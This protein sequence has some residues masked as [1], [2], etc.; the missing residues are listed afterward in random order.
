MKLH[1]TNYNDTFIAISEDCPVNIG[2]IPPNKAD[3]PSI[4]TL[5]YDIVSK[6]PYQF[7]SDEVLFQVYATRN[8]L[9]ESEFERARA[10]FFSKGQSCFRTS[11][12]A[13]RYGWGI[14]HNQ[15]GKIAIYGC[16][17]DQ[18]AAFLAD[19]MLKIVKAMK[20]SKNK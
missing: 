13:K 11:P 1:T 4:A 18:Y 16:E 9:I 19:N 10:T 3:I 2:E 20:S 6:N 17:T 5:H 14:H 7:T 8:D 12:L 15:A